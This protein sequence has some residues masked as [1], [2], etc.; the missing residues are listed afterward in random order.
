MRTNSAA[1][2]VLIAAVWILVP[3][4]S[5]RATFPGENGL[6]LFQRQSGGQTDQFTIR[7]DGTG[8][9]RRTFGGSDWYGSWSPDGR[10]IAFASARTGDFE[11]DVMNA[12]GGGQANLTV[13]GAND[14]WPNWSPDGGRITFQSDRDG[15]TDIYAMGADGS[16]PTRLTFDP[17]LDGQPAWS[18]DG[19]KLAF[20]SMR[21]GN[22]D[23]YVMNIDGTGVQRVTFDAAGDSAADWQTATPEDLVNNL[24]GAVEAL[25]LD[26]GLENSL[27]TKLEHVLADCGVLGAFINQ[28]EALAGGAID[29]GEAAALIAAATAVENL[30]GAQAYE[31]DDRVVI[32]LIRVSGHSR[33]RA[34]S[35][36]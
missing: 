35:V 17:A 26:S 33:K 16:S 31:G 14:F 4:T 5:V 9:T 25:G 19:T 22:T 10:R 32:G 2:A 8:E 36:G 13:N 34:P 11:I 12:D 29:E 18:P 6:I 24:V 27:V 21:G 1:S 15:N 28:T 23:V 3:A 30:L 20:T 7:P